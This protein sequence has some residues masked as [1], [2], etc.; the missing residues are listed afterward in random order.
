MFPTPM[1][2]TWLLFYARLEGELSDL[3][4]RWE[5]DVAERSREN[6]ARDVE[7]NTLRDTD[8]KLRAELSQRKLDVDRYSLTQV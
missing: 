3:K 8:V 7:L 1:C 4:L 6:V 2:H 5:S